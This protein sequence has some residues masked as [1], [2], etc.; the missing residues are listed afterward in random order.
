M[1][2]YLTPPQPSR[3][4]QRIADALTRYAP[5]SVTITP[6]HDEADLVVIY[7]I[8]RRERIDGQ[9]YHLFKQGKK[10]AI[11]Q[12][13]LRS[14]MNPR[15]DD[16]LQ[17]PD[18]KLYGGE[19]SYQGIWLNCHVIW[20]YY[21]LNQACVDDGWS[22]E[23]DGDSMWSSRQYL[24]APLGVDSAV[25]TADHGLPYRRRRGEYVIFT[26]GLSR[27]SESVRECHL[28]AEIVGRGA[29]HLG[30]QVRLQPKSICGQGFTDEQVAMIFTGCEF[31]S[32]L[33][34]K[35]GFELPAAEGLLCGAR[36]IVFDTPDYRWNY[37]EWAEYIHEGTRQ[38]VVDQLVQLFKQGARPVT[39]QER[40]EAAAWFNWERVCGEFWSRCL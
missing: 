29:F 35:E 23:Y 40:E 9:C 24:H 1:K 13:C 4:L 27:L 22:L 26:S 12:V 19:G 16:W 3:G 8:G 21:D 37:K 14:T 7:A 15:V 28:A 34:R 17:T 33:R 2:V 10:Y 39:E 25:F 31:V 11:I 20:S 32:G 38:E 36:P 18:P 30:P 5:Q 6:F